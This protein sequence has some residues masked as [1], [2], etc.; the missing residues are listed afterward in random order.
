[1]F[2][3]SWLRK[4]TTKH[5]PS[6]T[7]RSRAPRFRPR[8]EALEDRWL[9]S[10]LTVTTTADS[11]PGSLRAEIAAAASG[12]TIVFA[13]SLDGQ[14]IT[15]TSGELLL[16]QNLTIQGPG[17]AQLAISGNQLSRVFEVAANMQVTLAGLTILNGNVGVE[18][19][20]GGIYNNG[21]TVAL[22]HTAVT[23]NRP[24]NCAGS[25]PPI[26]ACSG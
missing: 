9:P 3:S 14:T 23:G 8:L 1:M 5:H 17:A 11:G 7:H 4:R 20:G 16:N 22:R 13:P 12:D 21:G 26:A 2:S 15:L 25:S 6:A 19:A 24:T 18:V 10:T